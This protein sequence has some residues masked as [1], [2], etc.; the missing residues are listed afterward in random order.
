MANTPDE[1]R[2]EQLLGQI[3]PQPTARLDKLTADAA[4]NQKTQISKFVY[5]RNA[6]AVLVILVIVVWTIPPLRTLAQDIIDDI[7]VR[8]GDNIWEA[9]VDEKEEREERLRIAAESCQGSNFDTITEAEALLGY[10]IIEPSFDNLEVI[11]VVARYPRENVSDTEE[12]VCVNGVDIHYALRETSYYTSLRISQSSLGYPLIDGMLIGADAEVENFMI[13]DTQLQYVIGYWKG[14]AVTPDEY[15][16]EWHNERIQRLA[17]E[18]DGFLM[19]IEVFQLGDKDNPITIE[20][21]L[22]IAESMI[23]PD[24]NS[25]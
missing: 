17:W 16:G 9:S 4:W 14:T 3:Q 22:A 15:S 5:L 20:E 18:Q 6:A 25:E 21:L 11:S 2:I 10:D 7:F 24:G 1:K 8:A 13:G 19:K 23:I 12:Q